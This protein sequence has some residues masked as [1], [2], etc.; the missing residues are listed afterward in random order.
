LAQSIPFFA[1]F[2]TV[3]AVIVLPF[4]L[5]DPAAMDYALRG[6]LQRDASSV[7]S[8]LFIALQPLLPAR[9]SEFLRF[10]PS[11]PALV[12][13]AAAALLALRERRVER[14][15][16]LV[17]LVYLVTLP[18]IYDRYLLFSFALLLYYS[19]R[20]S[21][22]LLAVPALMI[23]WPGFPYVSQVVLGLLVLGAIVV[24]LRPVRNRE[25]EEG[26]PTLRYEPTR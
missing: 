20:F 12:C 17:A 24:T 8:M 5:F 16:L 18:L 6:Q 11:L 7:Q 22:P 23:V 21:Q 19:A 13:T 26:T 2:G 25:P 15:M 10:N 3:L 4:L 14:V 9:L 1:A